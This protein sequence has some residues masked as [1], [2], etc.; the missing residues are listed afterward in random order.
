VTHP[1]FSS[2]ALDVD[3]TLAGIE[4][5]DWLATQRGEEIA[6]RVAELTDRA[7]RGELPLDAVYGERLALI[8]PTRREIDTLASEYCARL[9]PGA[10]VA[11]R[12]LVG[13]GVRIVLVSGGIREAIVPLATSLGIGEADVHAVSLRFSGD[14]AYAGYDEASPLATQLGKREVLVRCSLP[15]PLLA[16]GDGSTDV[17]MKRESDGFAAFTGFTSRPS[18]LAE[19]DH[20]VQSFAELQQLVMS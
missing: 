16:V 4:G 18:V 5:I 9:A 10:D 15:R 20:V 2:V 19:A 14:G 3:S 8:A 11:I 1:R 6:R 12:S 13:A 7:M 17:A